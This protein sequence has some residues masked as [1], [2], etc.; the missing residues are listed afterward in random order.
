MGHGGG[1]I[2]RTQRVAGCSAEAKSCRFAE[3]YARVAQERGCAFLDTGQMIIFSG[4]DGIHLEASEHGRLGAAVAARVREIL[5][6]WICLSMSPAD[7]PRADLGEWQLGWGAFGR[8]TV[9]RHDCIIL[10]GIDSYGDSTQ[11]WVPSW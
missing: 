1:N 4:L 3:H 5:G 10:P 8:L 9:V 11:G 6:G 2:G 7:A